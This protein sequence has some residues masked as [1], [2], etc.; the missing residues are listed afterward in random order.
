MRYLPFPIK[1]TMRAHNLIGEGAPEVVVTVT[2]AQTTREI[3]KVEYGIWLTTQQATELR[4]WLE[5]FLAAAEAK[6]A[7]IE[8]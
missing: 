7:R 1:L 3:P 5:K 6:A 2:E 8:Q 4:G